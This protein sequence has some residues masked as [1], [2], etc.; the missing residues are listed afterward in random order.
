M[1]SNS[2]PAGGPDWRALL[3]GSDAKA[4]E[5]FSRYKDPTEVG[6]AFLEQRSALSRRAEPL[7]ITPESTP[8]QVSEYRKAMGV[9][10]VAPDMPPDKAMEAYGIKAPDGYDLS[11]IERGMIGDFAKHAAGKHLPP[12][13]VKEATDFFFQSQAATGQAINKI[14]AT[15][16]KEW[17]GALRSEYGKD[18]D[19]YIAAAD[20]FIKQ[21]FRDDADGMKALLNAQMPD[22]GKL[23]D[24]A[25]FIKL[26]VEGAM[27]SGLTDRIEANAMESGGKSL[28]QQRQE[29]EALMFSDRAK[30]DLPATQQALDKVNS[31]LRARGE[32]DENGDIVRQRRSA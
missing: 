4:I 27:K 16:Q 11:E 2:E 12:A 6:K 28:M 22:G 32:I 8:E 29:I 23:G 31:L 9:P 17:Q 15:K 20:T 7:R 14:N 19:A 10:D 13:F 26:M 25:A 1:G 18:Y 30:Y 5:A 21:Q 3:A 24:N